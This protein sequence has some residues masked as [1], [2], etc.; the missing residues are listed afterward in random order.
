MMQNLLTTFNIQIALTLIIIVFSIRGLLA[1][2]IL[3]MWKMI[4]KGKF[5]INEH[6]IYK[7]LKKFF[8][9]LSIV[10]AMKLIP[11]NEKIISNW[12][13]ISKIITILF[14]TKLLTVIVSKDS[15]IMQKTIATSK[16]ETVNIFVCKIVKGI[17][18]IISGFVIIKELGYDLT[19]IAAGLG[20]G[21]V[22][23][24]LA[25]QDTVKSLLSGVVIFTDKPFEIGNWVQIGNY[26]GTVIDISFRSTRIKSK[27]NSIITIPNSVVTTE[28]VINWNK[29]KS[30]RF[31]CVLTL[32]KETSVE[33]TKK[34]ISQIKLVLKEHPKIKADS[35]EVF[36]DD[37]CSFSNEVK[38]FLYVNEANYIKYSKIK[39]EIYYELIT[40][41]EKENIDLA[42][43]TQTIEVKENNEMP[44]N[45]TKNRRK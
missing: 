18:W 8:V 36:L 17:I 4:S 23:I 39:E 20:V 45:K 40:L 2:F 5:E 41:L 13:E 19:G 37:I 31:D 27:D 43:P 33:K 44:D 35:V 21:S 1:T 25:A 29:L 9:F 22:I 15:K 6:P 26:Q 10:I 16:N 24:S 32:D 12:N 42:F 3:K 30:R 7:T 38:I 11:F 34:L 14:V 28:Y